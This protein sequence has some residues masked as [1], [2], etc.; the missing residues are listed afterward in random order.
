MTTPS[1]PANKDK[2]NAILDKYKLRTVK[3]IP[4]DISS[5]KKTKVLDKSNHAKNFAINSEK[6]IIIKSNPGQNSTSNISTPHTTEKIVSSTL[7]SSTLPIQKETPRETPRET[8]K[9]ISVNEILKR[10]KEQQI[11]VK[12]VMPIAVMPPSIGKSRGN[13][14]N[15]FNFIPKVKTESN[16]ASN[17]ASLQSKQD[18]SQIKRLTVT[19]VTNNMGIN[20]P[21]QSINTINTINNMRIEKTATP[22]KQTNPLNFIPVCKAPLHGNGKSQSPSQPSQIKRITID[23]TVGEK[24]KEIKKGHMPP[25]TNTNTNTHA[26]AQRTPTNMSVIA[27][28]QKHPQL[29]GTTIS[30]SPSPSLDT[31]GN[32]T[33]KILHQKRDAILRQQRIELDKIKFK[34]EQMVNLNNRKKEIALMK[35]IQLEQAKLQM[36]HQKQNDI[37]KLINAPN[38]APVSNQ[39]YAYNQL[40]NHTKKQVSLTVNKAVAAA[41]GSND[42]GINIPVQKRTMKLQTRLYPL[43]LSTYDKINALNSTETFKAKPTAKGH[44]SSVIVDETGDSAKVASVETVKLPIVE[45]KGRSKESTTTT[46]KLSNSLKYYSVADHPTVDWGDIKSLYDFHTFQNQTSF[47]NSICKFFSNSKQELQYSKQQLSTDEKHNLLKKTYGFKHLDN[48]IDNMSA[49]STIKHIPLI[50]YL[51]KILFFENIKI[52]KLAY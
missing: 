23:T 33:L 50:D 47:V 32:E 6:S 49:S 4:M 13:S 26:H 8:P 37:N 38:Q 16:N 44:I 35:S 3:N 25:T 20:Q 34:K 36:L 42:S 48:M 46:K 12:N 52:V 43:K 45:T 21:V 5:D 2:I 40:T 1:K 14:P 15:I 31:I 41:S 17:N 39:S 18:S 7:V 30:P 29:L 11:K 19:G 27:H 10:D 22:I 51:Y 24:Q 9:T 28:M